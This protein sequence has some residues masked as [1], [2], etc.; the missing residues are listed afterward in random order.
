MQ[1]L[2]I[3]AIALVVFVVMI[4][5]DIGG[6]LGAMAFL[7]IVLIGGLLRAWSPLIEWVRGPAA[8]L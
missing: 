6:T 3:T 2:V 4:G 5:I 1:L 8:K 7:L